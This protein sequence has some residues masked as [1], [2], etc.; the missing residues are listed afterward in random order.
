M[1]ARLTELVRDFR[2]RAGADGPSVYPGSPAIIRE[3][4]RAEDRA[5]CFE[6]HPADFALLRAGFEGDRRF[7]LKREDGFAGLKALLP[8]PSRRGCIFIDPPY[9]VREDYETLPHILTEALRRF[10]TGLYIIWYPL[11]GNGDTG[12]PEALMALYRGNRCRLE[13]R[14][15]EKRERGMYGSGLVV[16]NPPWTLKAALEESLP[17]LAALLGNGQGDW[18]LWWEEGGGEPGKPYQ[19]NYPYQY[20]YTKGGI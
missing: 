11:L 10:P 15:G 13:L 14:T 16:W 6:L 19:S 9:E 17:V 2:N 12:L 8:P 7:T 4:L 18:G 1:A 5:V 3:L 20:H